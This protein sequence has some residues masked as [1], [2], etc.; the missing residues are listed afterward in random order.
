M[1]LYFFSG[2]VTFI[3]S[4]Y[5]C[6]TNQ[7]NDEIFLLALTIILFIFSAIE[8]LKDSINNKN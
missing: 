7:L 6:L 8:E 1:K 3:G 5:F 4:I 2:V